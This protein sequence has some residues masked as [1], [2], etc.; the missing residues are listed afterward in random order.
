MVPLPGTLGEGERD[1]QYQCLM[2]RGWRFDHA[3]NLFND[4]GQTPPKY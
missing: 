1:M 2:G 4:D 3:F